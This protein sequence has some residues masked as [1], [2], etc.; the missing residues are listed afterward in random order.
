MDVAGGGGLVGQF[1][2]VSRRTVRSSHAA[3][4]LSEVFPALLFETAPVFV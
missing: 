2:M 4:R 3:P 1:K